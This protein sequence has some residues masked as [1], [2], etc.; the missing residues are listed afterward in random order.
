[1]YAHNARKRKQEKEEEAMTQYS[2]DDLSGW[3]FK[4]VRSTFGRFDNAEVLRRLIAEEAQNGWEMVEKFD[5]CRIRFKRRTDKRALHSGGGIDPYRTNYGPGKA[6]MPL[7]AVT[8]ALLLA[9]MMFLFDA[10]GHAESFIWPGIVTGM[11]IV[12]VIVMFIARRR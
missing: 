4:I 9:G 6:V 5:E 1:M 7:I 8:V 10:R 3:E 2:V 11:I 12:L